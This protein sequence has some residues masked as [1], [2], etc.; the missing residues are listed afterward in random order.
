MERKQKATGE[1][2]RQAN[3]RTYKLQIII[4]NTHY[5]SI[6]SLLPSGKGCGNS[7]NKDR[8]REEQ[9]FRSKSTQGF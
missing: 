1:E 2:E 6:A 9:L 3:K 7:Q 4:Q 5:P 8:N